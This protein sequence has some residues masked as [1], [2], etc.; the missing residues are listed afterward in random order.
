MRFS[1][2]LFSTFLILCNCGFTAL[3]WSRYYDLELRQTYWIDGYEGEE[4]L[5]LSGLTNDGTK[6]YTVSDV[7]GY[8]KIFEVRLQDKKAVLAPVMD[9]EGQWL[10]SYEKKYAGEGRIDLEGI[11]FCQ[12]AFYLADERKRKVLMVRDEQLKEIDP[13]FGQFHSKKDKM[14]PFSGVI[15]AGLEAIACDS[16]SSLLYIFNE[17][18]FRMG[19]S[20]SLQSSELI[21]QFDVPAGFNSPRFRDGFWVYPDFA[22][23]DF[24]QGRLY[25][26][27]RNDY[28]VVE[29]DPK[30]LKILRRFS[31]VNS[32][33]GLYQSPDIF[34]M[35]EG[36]T[37][38]DGKLFLIL[39]NNEFERSDKPGKFNPVLLEFSMPTDH[40]HR[41]H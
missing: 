39:D 1:A 2:L 22:G 4:K 28:A 23:A 14:N 11:A 30:D 32:S 40:N 7:Q 17:R 34:G 25:I 31:Y 13:R 36:I 3:S 27:E 24:H 20:Y 21:N 5:G 18:M 33:K 8:S 38:M 12:G 15:N 19:Y 16:S 26:L 10:E 41:Q 9:L 37:I 29:L 35:A 6:L